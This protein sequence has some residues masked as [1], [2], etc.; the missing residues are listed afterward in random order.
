ME[1]IRKLT[2]SDCRAIADAFKIRASATASICAGEMG[3]TDKQKETVAD[4]KKKLSDY[5]NGEKGSKDLTQK[6]KDE[7]SRLLMKEKN[8]ELPV[9]AKT[10]CK[11]WLKQYLFGRRQQLKNKYVAKGNSNEDDGF[12]LMAV[13]LGL[14]MV[15]KNTEYRENSFC[16]GTCDLHHKLGEIRIT[17]DNKCSWSLDTFPMFETELPDD[18]Y[19]WQLQ[20]YSILWPSDLLSLC[21][22][23]TDVDEDNLNREMKYISDPNER[24]LVACQMIFTTEAFEH[25]KSGWFP[26]A[27]LDSFVPIPDSD[28]VKQFK[29]KVDP[30]AQKMIEVRANMCKEYI[31][32]LLTNQL[33]KK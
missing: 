24:Y 7:L 5:K 14:G 9:G 25:A 12:T 1:P 10:Y 13:E 17:H 30:A 11:N 15:Y 6:Q 22:T 16:R 26:L 29:F 8:P 21:Y 32:E 19:W 33:N 31:F 23:L 4:F 28:R 20:T 2:V 18:K 3:L 27:T